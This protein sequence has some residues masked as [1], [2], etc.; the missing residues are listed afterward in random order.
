MPLVVE[1]DRPKWNSCLAAS[2]CVELSKPSL[3]NLLYRT[4]NSHLAITYAKAP[5]AEQSRLSQPLSYCHLARPPPLSFFWWL[6][7]L[8]GSP[9]IKCNRAPLMWNFDARYPVTDCH[10][11]KVR[12]LLVNVVASQSKSEKKH[13]SL[14]TPCELASFQSHDYAF[15]I[16]NFTL[17]LGLLRVFITSPAL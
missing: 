4:P 5:H 7:G 9:G 2:Q 6:T 3:P 14:E 8:Y 16:R 17:A 12:L 11:S 15:P 10:M 13:P 1:H